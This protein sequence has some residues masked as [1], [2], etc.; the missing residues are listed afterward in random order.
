MQGS[1]G[2][3]EAGSEGADSIF[4]FSTSLYPGSE[5]K[6]V[7]WSD[8]FGESGDNGSE[9]A[10]L[11]AGLLRAFKMVI[12]CLAVSPLPMF[13]SQLGREGHYWCVTWVVPK[14]T[15][16]IASTVLYCHSDFGVASSQLSPLGGCLLTLLNAWNE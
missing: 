6:H 8:T 15:R 13:P 10:F 12:T 16:D 1:R 2:S 3:W 4:V 11:T 7:H 14:V 9:L 5:L